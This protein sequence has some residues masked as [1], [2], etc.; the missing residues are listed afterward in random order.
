MGGE[1]AAAAPAQA[2]VASH[3]MLALLAIGVAGLLRSGSA[4]PRASTEPA[5]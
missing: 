3:V 5:R 2:A 1:Q 4:A